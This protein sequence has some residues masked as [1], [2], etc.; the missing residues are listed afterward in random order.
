ME[1]TV[2]TQKD[3]KADIEAANQL[4]MEAMANG[5]TTM[6]DHYTSDAQLFP[7]G[8][9]VIEGK[10]AIGSFWKAV[11]ESGVKR[12]T[13]ETTQAEQDG[14]LV[15]ETGRYTLYGADDTQLD[16][17]KY[18]VVWK[19]EDGHWKLHQD[20]FNTSIPAAAK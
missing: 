14:E 3:R 2:L 19:Q 16:V 5:A 11:Y 15:I 12:A 13:L 17:G 20:I 9:D 10:Q 7:P 4:F 8:T 18:L 1:N 6:G